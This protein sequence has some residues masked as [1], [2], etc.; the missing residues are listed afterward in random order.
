MPGKKVRVNTILSKKSDKQ[1]I[2]A[3]TAYNYPTGI[4]VENSG[5]DLVLVGDSL[6]NNVLGFDSTIPVTMDHIIHHCSAVSRAVKHPLLVADM[7]FMTYKVSVEKTLENAAR[8]LGEGGAEAVKMEGGTEI[9][10]MVA[11]VI[12]A[13]IPVL[14]HIGLTPQSVHALS[15]M[16]I[17][18]RDDKSIARLKTDALKLQELGCF[19]IVLELIAAQVAQEISDELE[20]P[21]IGIGAGVGCDGQ[22]LVLNDVIGLNKGTPPKFV[23]QY[24]SLYEQAVNA[25]GTYASEVREGKYPDE[26]HSHH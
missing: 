15:G 7:P 13:G 14:G 2:V 12:Q 8:M 6:G 21:T 10:P 11:A 3:V 18:G 19:A 25:V 5:V 24:A 9:A 22:I 17:Q 26:E 1:K 16:R 20:I 23:K 4:I